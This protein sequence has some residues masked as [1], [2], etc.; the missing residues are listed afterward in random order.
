MFNKTE[1]PQGVT[2][3]PNRVRD[4][5]GKLEF[6]SFIMNSRISFEAFLTS[7]SDSFN[8]NWRQ[9]PVY[10]RMDPIHTFQ[11]TQRTIGLS[12]TV[13]N[14]TNSKHD[15]AG[16]DFA[17]ARLNM[18]FQ[19]LYPKY[20]GSPNTLTISQAPLVRMKFGNMIA[21]SVMSSVGSVKDDGLLGAITS[22]SMTPKIEHGFSKRTVSTPPPSPETPTDILIYPNF[23]DLSLSFNVIHEQS[24]LPSPREFSV[25]NFPYGG[26]LRAAEGLSQGARSEAAGDIIQGAID[27]PADWEDDDDWRDI[28]EMAGAPGEDDDDWRSV[29]E[30]SGPEDPVYIGD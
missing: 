18:F 5:G 2:D 21:R 22:L 24:Q 25:S 27:S 14:V 11:N 20:D 30:L 9:D 28:D 3:L 1:T 23:I 15:F 17:M 19:F 26:S 13:P 29:D 12:F 10:G 7:Y 8:S 4:A 6:Y 16:V